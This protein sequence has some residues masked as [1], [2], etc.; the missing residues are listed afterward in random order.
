M[1]KLIK[2]NHLAAAILLSGIASSVNAESASR[3]YLALSQEQGQILWLQTGSQAAINTF[4]G[5]TGALEQTVPLKLDPSQLIM[6]F[7]PDGF[8]VAVLEQAG[9]SILHRTGKT[10][11]TLAISNLPQPASRYQPATAITNA[12]G[13]A[14][15]FHDAKANQLQVIHTGNGKQ[16]ATID[17]PQAPLLALGLD[18]TMN[19]V[20]YVTQGTDGQADLQVYDVFK[21]T[22][23]KTYSIAAPKAFSQPVVFSQDGKYAAL[24][25]QLIN[26][27]TEEV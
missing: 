16:L 1:Q 5:Q 13:T 19:K 7:T 23:V 11:R 3:A 25:P 8:K 17:L 24:L 15:L 14:Q 18:V 22:L 6:G 9:L 27:E 26:L 20:A 2:F 4:N 10:L 12:T 21:K